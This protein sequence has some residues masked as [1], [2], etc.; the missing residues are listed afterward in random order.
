MCGLLARLYLEQAA[1]VADIVKGRE[2][3][4]MRR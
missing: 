3:E 1:A 2:E 4:R